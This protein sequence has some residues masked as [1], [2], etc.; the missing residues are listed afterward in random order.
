M[1][2]TNELRT[3]FFNL[4][5]SN[6]ADCFVPSGSTRHSNHYEKQLLVDQNEAFRVVLLGAGP[7][8]L[9]CAAIRA[10]LA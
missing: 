3:F 9:P 8:R 10:A 7:T 5:L 2:Q 4:S 6:R 1:S